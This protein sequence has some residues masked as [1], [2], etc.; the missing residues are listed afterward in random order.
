MSTV[1]FGVYVPSASDGLRTIQRATLAEEL[2]FDSVWVPDLIDPGLMEC[3]TLSAAIATA[4][5]RI[6]VGLGVTNFMYRSPQLLL[7]T[8]ATLDQLSQGR[9]NIGIGVG[10]NFCFAQYGLTAAPYG[11]RVAQLAETL[12][13]MRLHFNEPK[14]NYDGE[15]LQFKDVDPRPFPIQQPSPPLLIGG[16]SSRMLA[17][18]AKHAD[19][20]EIGGW[21]S[22]RLGADEDKLSV[23]VRKRKEL[24]EL[25]ERIGR[26]PKEI[27][28]L[29]D[30]WFTM[31]A[32]EQ[33]AQSAAARAAPWA[34]HYELHSGTPPVIVERL[35]AYVDA[36]VGHIILSFLNFARGDTPRLFRQEVAN[37]FQ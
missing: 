9:L 1:E 4:T 34:E 23:I 30:F 3:M 36:G 20:W 26:D 22:Y 5:S 2:C 13:V 37:A 14:V 29:S 12:E 21:R 16:G 10:V 19:L 17:L 15:Y 11:E 6:R 33:E 35:Q 24:D 32:S 27:K 8:L 28:T 31:G 18:A 25:C 7:R